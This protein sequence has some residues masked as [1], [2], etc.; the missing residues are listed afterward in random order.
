MHRAKANCSPTCGVQLLINDF[1]DCFTAKENGHSNGL[2]PHGGIRTDE[3][4]QVSG[5]HAEYRQGFEE[6]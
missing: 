1:S 5:L 6:L 4:G 2:R 3:A